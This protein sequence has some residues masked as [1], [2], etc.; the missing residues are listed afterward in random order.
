MQ[1]ASLALPPY[2]TLISIRNILEWIGKR[3]QMPIRD[4]SHVPL[5]YSKLKSAQEAHQHHFSEQ[6]SLDRP[7]HTRCNAGKL[8][9]AIQQA[10]IKR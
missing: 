5:A 8:A 9:P 10:W 7:F 3:P 1:L 4:L 6:I 2:L